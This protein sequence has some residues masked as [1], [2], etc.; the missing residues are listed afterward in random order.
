VRRLHVLR[1][2]VFTNL[3][4]QAGLPAMAWPI[5]PPWSRQPTLEA[6]YRWAVGPW[7]EAKALYE[8]ALT[9]LHAGM[10]DS[11]PGSFPRVSRTGCH[12]QTEKRPWH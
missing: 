5:W 7:P 9:L 1:R 2:F 12:R 4:R 3:Q 10:A 6:H 8:A 11:L